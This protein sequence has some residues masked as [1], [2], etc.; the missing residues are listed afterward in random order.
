MS[1]GKRYYLKI[2]SDFFQKIKV[3]KLRKTKKGDA[4]TCIYLKLMLLSTRDFG[5]IT[6]QGIEDTLYEELALIIDEEPEDVKF[7]MEFLEKEKIL[8][9]T[10]DD[11]Y[12]FENLCNEVVTETEYARKMRKYRAKKREE[13]KSNKW[14]ITM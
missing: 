10:D 2:D 9:Q 1:I 4:Y 11:E 14:Q 6:F 8:L 5:L 3:K 12:L 13:I 7:T